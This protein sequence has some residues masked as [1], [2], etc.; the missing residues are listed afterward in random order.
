MS[1]EITLSDA[2]FDT[3][4]DA[5]QL[6]VLVDFWAPWC[7]PCRF[8]APILEQIAD[9]KADQLKIGKLNVDDNPQVAM[10]YGI[11][12]IPT[13]ILFKGGKPVE[14]IVGALPKEHLMRALA[15]HL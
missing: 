2:D 8:I 6:P 7:G 5:A 3:T 11:Q 14:R 15:P 10:R 1:R 12:G 13:M 9:E 4:I